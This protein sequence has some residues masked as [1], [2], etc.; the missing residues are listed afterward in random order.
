[1][2][3]DYSPVISEAPDSGRSLHAMAGHGGVDVGTN[4]GSRS[5]FDDLLSLD[6]VSVGLLDLVIKELDA[7]VEVLCSSEEDGAE[8]VLAIDEIVEV[9]LDLLLLFFT[10]FSNSL[11]EIIPGVH[12]CLNDGCCVGGS[13]SALYLGA[14][15]QFSETHLCV[16]LS[17]KIIT[18]TFNNLPFIP[19]IATY[20]LLTKHLIRLFILLILNF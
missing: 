18:E 11:L 14:D 6:L 17:I 1:M 3:H 16:L 4:A 2:F 15:L 9:I 12:H 7:R 10:E 5:E 19:S 13:T 8:V 20:F